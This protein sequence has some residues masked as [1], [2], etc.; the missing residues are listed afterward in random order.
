MVS[1]WN[2]ESPA[3]AYLKSLALVPNVEIRVVT[4]PKASTGFIPFARVIH[5]KTMVIDGKLAWVGTSNWSGGYFDLSRNIEVVMRN[6]QMA[7]R[8][9]AL[10][11]QTWSSPYAQPLDVNKNYPKPNKAKEE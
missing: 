11:E 6:E 9:A 5:S 2:L 3:Q 7:K 10:H 4:L 8:L 1:N